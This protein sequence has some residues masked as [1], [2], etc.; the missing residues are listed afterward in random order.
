MYP[1]GSELFVTFAEAMDVDATM[2]DPDELA[3]HYLIIDTNVFI[4]ALDVLAQI[5]QFIEE[6]HANIKFL[7]PGAPSNRL[8]LHT[9]KPL[10]KVSSS[11]NSTCSSRRPI[12][13]IASLDSLSAILLVKR[14]TFSSTSS[15]VGTTRDVFVDKRTGRLFK[16][17]QVGRPA[18]IKRLTTNCMC[19]V[20]WYLPRADCFQDLGLRVVLRFTSQGA[21][22]DYGSEFFRHESCSE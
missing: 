11:R 16:P 18:L 14:P 15:A 12:H 3:A 13:M 17:H 2:N 4:S 22:H 19:L 6:K 1:N 5:A 9:A 7:L 21:S 10:N 8:E 20:I